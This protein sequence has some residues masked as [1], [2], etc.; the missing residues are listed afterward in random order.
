M[1]GRDSAEINIRIDRD[2]R[3]QMIIALL[4][5][6]KMHMARSI[7]M[8]PQQLQQRAHRPIMRDRIRHWNNGL[9]PE[10]PV[11]IT[12]HDRSTVRPVSIRVLHVVEALRVRL[13]D[14]DRG[15]GDR[16]AGRVFDGA[17]DE[18]GFAFRVV[19]DGAAVR[20]R[21]SFVRVEGAEDGAFG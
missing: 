18:A 1:L 19:R 2:V 9:E 4:L 5:E 11:L 12:T 20:G 7:R 3:D 8:P 15:V 16:A 17:E 10:V 6:H 14:V 13:P 21:L